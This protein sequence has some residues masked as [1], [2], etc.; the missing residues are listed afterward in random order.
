V[1]KGAQRKWIEAVCSR[2]YVEA[3]DPK[4]SAG[5]NAETGQFNLPLVLSIMPSSYEDCNF[6]LCVPRPSSG[7]NPEKSI[8]VRSSKP[9]DIPPY[10]ILINV[11]R[12]GFSANKYVQYLD[13]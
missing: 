5:T 1:D 2:V 12:F 3:C 11:D 10:H 9:N 7:Q 6:T 4:F 8:I 13:I